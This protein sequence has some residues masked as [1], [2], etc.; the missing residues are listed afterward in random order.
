[1][2]PALVAPVLP[3]ENGLTAGHGPALATSQ[4]TPPTS[5]TAIPTKFVQCS[6]VAHL[7]GA[8]G[9]KGGAT[10]MA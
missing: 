5:S 6:L 1:V 3:I 7:A 4:S 9:T 2:V 10:V 8:G